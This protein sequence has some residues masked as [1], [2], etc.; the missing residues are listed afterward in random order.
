MALLDELVAEFPAV[1]AYPVELARSHDNLG[2]LSTSTA[3]LA[4]AT[5]HFR[6]SAAVWHRLAADNPA[7]VRHSIALGDAYRTLGVAVRNGGEP[8]VSLAWFEKAITTVQVAL[9]QAP[10]APQGRQ[11]LALIHSGRAVTRELLNQ[12]AEAVADWDRAVE[13]TDKANTPGFRARRA[14]ARARAGSSP[15]R[16]PRWPS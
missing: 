3:D 9:R 7:D 4:V 11:L 6:K 12:Y 10:N 1:T 16:S 2:K 8:A 13:L 15:R 5:E 14:T